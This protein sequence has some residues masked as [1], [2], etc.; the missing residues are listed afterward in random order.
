MHRRLVLAL[1]AVTGCL[2]T[3]ADVREPALAMGVKD[4][5]I[6]WGSCPDFMPKGCQLAVLHG[7]PTQ[8]NADVFLKVPA[9]SRIANHWHSSAERMV[10]VAGEME[11][12]YEGQTPAA[13]KPGMYAY[14]PAKRSHSAFCSSSEACVLFI[15]FESAVDAVATGEQS[16]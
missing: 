2:A 6:K 5:Q 12:T 10:L 14:G 13:L 16:H 8:A 9:G 3:Q 15:A 1:C 7:D 4:P 11:V